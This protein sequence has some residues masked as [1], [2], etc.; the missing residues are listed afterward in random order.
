MKNLEFDD[1]NLVTY[2]FYAGSI[3]LVECTTT[4]QDTNKVR[5]VD[6]KAIIYCKFDTGMIATAT[7]IPLTIRLYYGYM[8]YIS[9]PVEKTAEDVE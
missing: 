9:Q 8:D 5:L 3:S 2:D 4:V 1:Y 6:N 7:Q